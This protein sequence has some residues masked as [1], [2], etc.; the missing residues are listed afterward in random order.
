VQW[1]SYCFLKSWAKYLL[2]K[3]NFV[4]HKATTKKPKISVS[5]FEEI[6]PQFLMD[7]MASVTLEKIPSDMVI[8]WD[9]TA[10][11]YIPLSTGP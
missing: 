11:K 2:A 3:M 7:I 4:K 9:Q 8:N 5:N 6:K 10:I 1:R